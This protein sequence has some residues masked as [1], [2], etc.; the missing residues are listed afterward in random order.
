MFKI[1]TKCKK[2]FDENEKKCP[3]CGKRLKVKYTEEELVKMKKEEEEAV[4]IID[5]LMM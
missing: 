4:M 5:M 2:E 3:V 1:C